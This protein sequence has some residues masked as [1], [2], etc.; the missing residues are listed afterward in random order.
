[1]R[2]S[3]FYQLWKRL[4]QRSIAASHEGASSTG[5]LQMHLMT[6][7]PDEAFLAIAEVSSL[8]Y[9]MSLEDERGCLSLRELAR[10]GNEIEQRLRLHS[11]NKQQHRADHAQEDR[12]LN[13]HLRDSIKDIFRETAA[14]YL[15]VILNGSKP[16]KLHEMF[17]QQKKILLN[18]R[19]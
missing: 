13:Q 16:G 10:K 18:L 1:M 15:Y 3:E 9:W 8:S 5:G 6:G 12:Y 11:P 7:C 17:L 19:L 4:L 14:L 2:P